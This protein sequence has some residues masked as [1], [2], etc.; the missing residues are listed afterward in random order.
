MQKQN[1]AL[2][3]MK[4]ERAEFRLRDGAR[5]RAEPPKRSF[6]HLQ[7]Y[8]SNSGLRLDFDED[9]PSI[10]SAGEASRMTSEG[11]IR[12]SSHLFN[13][14]KDDS[15]DQTK[16]AKTYHRPTSSSSGSLMYPVQTQVI[17]APSITGNGE[18]FPGPANKGGLSFDDNEDYSSFA[19]F[20]TDNEDGTDM[21]DIFGF[22]FRFSDEEIAYCQSSFYSDEEDNTE[23]KKN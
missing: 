8:A 1:G 7:N 23:P 17:A 11:I 19:I 10:S 18:L 5:D 2:C 22:G 12:T 21:H 13:N 9:L 16:R 3:D 20:A 14:D 15:Q 4:A 6:A